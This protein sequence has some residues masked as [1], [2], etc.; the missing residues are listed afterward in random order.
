MF[1]EEKND[2]SYDQVVSIDYKKNM[3]INA[4]NF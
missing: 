3:Y 1:D 4:V 2:V